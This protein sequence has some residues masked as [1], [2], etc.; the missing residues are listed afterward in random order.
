MRR[1][2]GLEQPER[3]IGQ[4]AHDFSMLAAGK[5][6]ILT[7]ALKSDGVPT[8]ASRWLQRLQQLV[9]GLGLRDSL[10]PER[11]YVAFARSL[12]DP[13]QPQRMRRPAPSPPVEARPKELSIT[14][15]ETW[16]R[17]PY[18]IYAKRVLRL[19][20]LDPLDADIGPMERGSAVHKALELFVQ[21]FPGEL[22]PDAVLQLIR[23]SDEVF[24]ALGTP[25]AALAL[26]RPRFANAAVWFVGQERR[27]R[28]AIAQSHVEIDGRMAVS[29]GFS[30]YGR[31]DRIDIL[32]NGGAAILDYKTGQPPTGSQIR[33]FLA[34]QLLLEG[35]M[36]EAGGFGELGKRQTEALIY[37]QFSGGK[38]PGK[39]QNVDTA[40]IEE[41]LARLRQ[42]VID[43][44]AQSMPYLPRVKPFQAG[45]PGDYD[46]LS[47]VREWSLSGWED[48]DE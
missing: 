25:K 38:E 17:D 31:A 21:R 16:I 1:A 42:R 4:A 43:F 14:D 29:D 6:V 18:A 20:P 13:G 10:K 5:R 39:L 36:I 22:P 12:G 23:I 47:R 24:A 41:A 19:R 8:V 46:H 27:R 28:T 15:I 33:K 40:L 11:D 2:I 7:R 37:L 48:A 9:N 30:L 32:K 34:P 3:S 44:A 45:T 35:A 26:W